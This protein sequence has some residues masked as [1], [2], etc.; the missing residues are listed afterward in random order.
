[1][2]SLKI[3]HTGD[4]H[5]GMTYSRYPAAIQEKLAA[6]RVETLSHLISIANDQSCNIFVIAG[7]LFDKLRIKKSKVLEVI[8]LLARFSGEVL[9]ILPGNHDF[10]DHA[11][12]LWRHVHH[13]LPN[14]A[15]LLNEDRVYP[16]EHYGLDVD[17]YPAYC[18][19]RHSGEN[20]LRW[21]QGL[22][23][24][25]QSKIN[26]GIAHGTLEGHSADLQGAYFFMTSK[27]LNDIPMDLWLLGHTHVRY[28]DSDTVT[29][30]NI[31]YCGTPEPDGLN[32]SG[33]GNAWIIEIDSQKTI[34][35]WGIATGQYRFYDWRF[36][37]SCQQ[38]LSNLKQMLLPDAQ[39]NIVR[40]NL[41]GSVDAELLL[42]YREMLKE[43][44]E[45]LAYLE[46]SDEGLREKLNQ[47]LIDKEFTLNS[48][49]YRLLTKLIEKDHD[50]AQIAYDLIR[51]AKNAN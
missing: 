3:L 5:I 35:A 37:I 33:P 9:L 23:G 50:A 41:S 21:M 29:H 11:N 12:D 45:K 48:V 31:F 10:D 25:D 14:N 18:D 47:D 17:V 4:L 34:H 43:L 39:R 16:L 44:E 19:K 26:L 46:F 42:Q 7:D 28:P 15:V 22:E 38:D 2:M 49:P 51:R 30:N 32:F 24:F 40:L 13:N 6:A 8:N 1:M 27:E 36:V 20:K